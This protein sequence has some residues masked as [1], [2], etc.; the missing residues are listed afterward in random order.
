MPDEGERQKASDR[1]LSDPVAEAERQRRHQESRGK[2]MTGSLRDLS[3]V[4]NTTEHTQDILHEIEHQSD[5]GVALIVTANLEISLKMAMRSRL[6]AYDDF[7]Q[8]IFD[9][10]GAPLSTF[11]DRIKIARAM[12]VIGQHVEAHLDSIRHI[13]NQFAHSPLRIDFENE[14]IAAEIDNLWP[15]NPE[16]RPHWTAGK[17]R[18][19]G[20]AVCLAQ[21]LDHVAGEHYND[22]I[23][24]W[25]S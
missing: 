13:R 2:K 4:E 15:D 19:V 9:K 20:T 16:W 21:A 5:R 17:R 12:G 11:S 1:R 7:E 8:T 14:L 6:V 18:F 23:P 10:E 22:T 25:T 24:I 3:K